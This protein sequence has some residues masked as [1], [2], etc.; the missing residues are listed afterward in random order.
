MKKRIIR[1]CVVLV[2]L[3]LILLNIINT[4]NETKTKDKEIAINIEEETLDVN[5]TKYLSAGVSRTISQLISG[6]NVDNFIGISKHD[7]LKVAS[8]NPFDEET[9]KTSIMVEEN[10]ESNEFVDKIVNEVK[11]QESFS[12]TDISQ[13]KYTICYLNIRKAPKPDGEQ[14]GIYPAYQEI[15][16]SGVTNDGWYRVDYNGEVAYVYGEYLSDEKPMNVFKVSSTAYYNPN[17]NKTA[18]GSNTIAN[19][20]LAGKS[21]WLG[22]ACYLYACN[23]DG[24]IGECLGYYEFHDTGYGRDGDIPRGETID[25]YMNTYNECVN[26][27]RRNIYVQFIN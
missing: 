25:I 15:N 13:I 9:E 12:V 23:S 1:S 14:I 24:S 5:D 22:K 17:G 2:G 6:D 7:Y 10:E 18:D 3:L 20:T 27:G 26:Y 11:V 8:A 16:V 19:L 4:N 21:E